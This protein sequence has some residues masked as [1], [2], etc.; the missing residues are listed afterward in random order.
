MIK[1]TI[2]ARTYRAIYRLLDRVS[3]VDFDCGMLCNAACC[4]LDDMDP[5]FDMDE[6]AIEEGELE[7]DMGMIFLP[8][9]DKIHDK[10]DSWLEWYSDSTD[11]LDYPDSWKGQV[12]FAK[13]QGHNHCNR[14]MRPIQCR[15][16]PVAPHLDEQGKLSLVLDDLELPYTCPLQDAG[17]ELVLEERFLRA[18]YTAWKRLITDP[19]IYDLVEAD[20][21]ERIQD[22]LIVFWPKE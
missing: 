17:E 5:Y 8:G 3:P 9:E 15:T 19:L 22:E 14:K 4:N 18:T 11:A 21:H 20:S 16:F 6:S 1:S 13:C 12:Y 2:T 7:A 10:K